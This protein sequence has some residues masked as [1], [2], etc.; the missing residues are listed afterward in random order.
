MK[1]KSA[2]II[3]ITFLLYFLNQVF[4]LKP[5]F[6][7]SSITL[8][9]LLIILL[10]RNI[11]K[12]FRK[13]GWLVWLITPI[14][15][16]FSASLYSTIVI[17]SFWI[18]IIFLVIAWFMYSYF[19]NLSNYLPNKTP[20]R[21][22]KFDNLVLS[23]GVLICVTS[24]A[25][26]YGL[27]SF[28]SWSTSFLLLLFVPIAIL[29]FFQFAPLRKNFWQ[30]NK[31]LLPINILLLLELAIVLSFLPLNFN[32]LGFVLAIGYYFLLSVMRFRWQERLEYRNIKRL[33][34]LMVVIVLILFLST[35]WL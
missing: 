5:S 20:E 11:V 27:T 9:G 30:E 21:N 22:K 18:Q 13:H 29:L 7:Y 12:S 17:S 34:I 31:Y 8:G 24:G 35:R 3:L 23:G 2:F 26:L 25:S 10:T 1:S 6:F 28:I 33:V 32:L 16:W 19:N 15:F 14:L 4:L